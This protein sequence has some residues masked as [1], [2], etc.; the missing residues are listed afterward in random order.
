VSYQDDLNIIDEAW[1]TFIDTSPT[2]EQVRL[3]CRLENAWYR[4]GLE[5]GWYRLGKEEA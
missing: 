2:D 4:L 3:V 5:N 1:G